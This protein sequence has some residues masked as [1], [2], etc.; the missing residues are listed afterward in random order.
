MPRPANCTEAPDTGHSKGAED[1]KVGFRRR[2]HAATGQRKARRGSMQAACDRGRNAAR[3][4]APP[5]NLATDPMHGTAQPNPLGPNLEAL[6]VSQ[7]WLVDWRPPQTGRVRV[8]NAEAWIKGGAGAWLRLHSRRAPLDEAARWIDAITPNDDQTIVVIGLGLGHLLEALEHRGVRPRVIAF[9]PEPEVAEACLARRDWRS[10]IETGRLRLLV[11]PEY[12]GATRAWRW[13]DGPVPRVLVHP[14]LA[15]ARAKE[16]ATAQQVVKQ[17]QF[18]A[19]ANAEARRKNAGRYLLNTLRNLP[20]VAEGGAVRDLRGLVPATPAVVIGAGPALDE[21]IR[22]LAALSSRVVLIAADTALRPL[23]RA[24]IPPHA[25]VT[26]DPTSLNADHLPS[27]PTGAP[28]WLVA[29]PSVDPR[30]LRGFPTRT[31]FFALDHHP[32]PWLRDNGVDPGGLLAWG[33]VVTTGFDLARELG[34]DPIV[35]AGL[36]LAFTAGRPYCRGTM[37]EDAWADAT[38]GGAALDDVWRDG[39]ALWEPVETR[40]VAGRPTSTARHLLSYRDWLLD[41]VASSDRRCLNATG[42]G[43]LVGPSVE[44]TSLAA[45]AARLEGHPPDIDERFRAA[46]AAS[47]ARGTPVWGWQ[48]RLRSQIDVTG[49]P[50]AEPIATWLDWAPE[51]TRDDLRRALFAERDERHDVPTRRDAGEP[52]FAPPARVERPERAAILRAALSGQPVP[53]W[54]R[55]TVTT[56]AIGGRTTPALAHALEL[57]ER[58]V[59]ADV[60]LSRGPSPVPAS[61]PGPVSQWFRWADATVGAAVAELEDALAALLLH[62]IRPAAAELSRA[63]QRLAGTVPDTASTGASHAATQARDRIAR[64]ALLWQTA[65]VAARLP[66]TLTGTARDP[67]PDRFAVA[68]ITR[69]IRASGHKPLLGSLGPDRTHMSGAVPHLAGAAVLDLGAFARRPGAVRAPDPPLTWPPRVALDVTALGTTPEQAIHVVRPDGRT[70]IV[71]WLQPR[72]LTGDSLPLCFY[73]A[74]LDDRTAVFTPPHARSGFAISADGTVTPRPAWPRPIVAEVPWGREGG[75]VAW[76]H[77]NPGYVMLRP[78]AG[79]PVCI[80][81]LPIHASRSL[82]RPDGSVWWTSRR[83]GLWSWRRG[84][85]VSR[86]VATPPAILSRA[87]QN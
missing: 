58:L 32:W 69:L 73:G 71:T 24:G 74:T 59:S 49:G 13:L 40:D 86:L 4:D 75:A 18:D 60:G 36:D 61:S 64:Q 41:H 33:S 35:F 12:A 77:G 87:E 53:A 11:G 2:T 5:G 50:A 20:R 8:R 9:E 57:L 7:G 44:Q 52:A 31:F 76:G 34:C 56:S 30:A 42:A 39:L 66:A 3:R 21:N 78:S 63:V 79:A 80:D 46:H 68:C 45:I 26:I 10:W 25:V 1:N 83:G 38:K 14:V 85:G 81:D 72:R 65:A 67:R 55:A 15:R 29:E 6:A 47:V 23:I 54:V 16:V 17:I 27:A 48:R 51:L 22:D 43:V 84:E 37:W 82:V 28:T 19:A 62:Q 70:T